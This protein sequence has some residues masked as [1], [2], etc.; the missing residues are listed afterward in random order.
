MRI[1]KA[2]KAIRVSAVQWQDTKLWQSSPEEYVKVVLTAVVT[3]VLTV[4]LEKEAF[5][6]ERKRVILNRRI[7][8]P[9]EERLNVDVSDL[10]SFQE[11]KVCVGE[12]YLRCGSVYIVRSANTLRQ[13]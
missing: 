6:A 2:S 11:E 5:R 3:A 13:R 12:C 1:M 10:L 8:S 7:L 9:L 4:S